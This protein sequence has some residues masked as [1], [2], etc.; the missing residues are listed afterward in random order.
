MRTMII[1]LNPANQFCIQL[2][3]IVT[4]FATQDSG[5]FTSLILFIQVLLFEVDVISR[6]T[7][8]FIN[9]M[10]SSFVTLT[11]AVSKIGFSK[12][13]FFKLMPISN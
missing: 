10:Q 13:Y 6:S 12:Q 11:M 2:N 1:Y 9:H 4:V 7:L 8:K 3:V 5:T